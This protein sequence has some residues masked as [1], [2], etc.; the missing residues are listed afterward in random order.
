[1]P[2]CK[3]NQVVAARQ[4]KHIMT[5]DLNA[6][7]QS[8]PTFPGKE[9]HFLRAQLA[10]IFAATTIA[11][12]GLFEIDEDTQ[13]MKF[14]EDFA[15]PSA[16][17]M[18]SLENWSNVSPS[19]LLNGRTSYVAPKGLDE[20]AAEAWM[21]DKTENDPQVDRFRTL[22]Q[23][24]PSQGMETSWVS[25][26][27][28]DAQQYTKGEG[29][30]AYGVNVIKSIRWPGALTVCKGGKFTNVYIGYGVKREGPSF[31]PTVPPVVDKE[32]QDPEEQ[33]EPNP[34]K[35]PVEPPA[36]NDENQEAE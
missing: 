18:K 5:G 25:K 29:T 22:D 15:M 26:L 7:I 9:R 32:P 36:E 10:R 34:D 23:H 13:L 11:P 20:E 3:P 17:D 12:K 24:A 28:G 30:V 2:D 27:A 33:P 8:N 4:I 21:A 6:E 14:A 31:N 16:D 35:D 1:M 19:I